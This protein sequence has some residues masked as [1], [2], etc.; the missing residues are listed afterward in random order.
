M[1]EKRL[2]NRKDF[3]LTRQRLSETLSR[4]SVF[5]DFFINAI[6]FIYIRVLYGVLAILFF[7]FKVKLTK[8]SSC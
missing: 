8:P 1:Q 7:K 4:M 3:T 6:F 2:Q 5:T